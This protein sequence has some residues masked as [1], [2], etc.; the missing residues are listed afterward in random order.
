[1]PNSSEKPVDNPPSTAAAAPGHGL[2]SGG[3]PGRPTVRSL[4]GLLIGLALFGLLLALPNPAGMSIAA[5]RT[6][7]VTVLMAT[8]WI[9]EALPVPAT[10]LLP[11]ALFPLLGAGTLAEATAP[12]ANPILFLF[13]GGFLL[14]LAIERWLL[15]RRIA[16]F[17]LSRVGSRAD[18]IVGGFLL[19]TALLSMWLSNTATAVMMLPIAVSVLGLLDE[20]N[21]AGD[22]DAHPAGASFAPA[23]LLS[24]AYGASIG[25]IATLV[26]T[27]PNAMLA[28]FFSET[29]GVDISFA[30]WMI[31]GLPVSV[32]MLAATWWVLTRGTL[33]VSGEVRG[34]AQLIGRERQKLGSWSRGERMVG[35]MF[36]LTATAWILRP[37]LDLWLP[38]L[39]LSDAGIAMISAIL[40]FALPVD[41]SD[42]RTRF[43]MNWETAQR[44]PWGV[45]LLFGG[46]LSV[47]DRI[48]A[49][50]VAAWIG[51]RFEDLSAWP[52][53]LLLALVVTTIVFLTELTSNAATTATF[54]PVVAAMA[55][56]VGESPL[57]FA[58]PTALAASC[59][60]MM[61]VATPPNA[62]VYGSGRVSIGHM[63]RAG[64]ALNGVA[65][66][67]ILLLGY[68]VLGTAL[69]VRLGD[70]PI[71]AEVAR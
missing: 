36:L 22:A 64:L 68:F 43:L 62:I 31:V 69:G 8:W 49:T 44:V 38:R 30:R 52:L 6:T 47:A 51:L 32:L 1:M 45:L 27:P 12:Y 40:L 18:R 65:I 4:S 10:A 58:V 71:W 56:S 28:G 66:V 55:V 16:L 19:G 20:S 2:H 3:Q 39:S 67:V 34:A 41:T 50:G 42:G 61:P 11:V 14:A 59:A 25:G 63:A 23:L 53:I 17:I 60:F 70:V 21:A 7:A 37:Q 57:L 15:H 24:V 54:L 29:Y 9:L 13:L 35:V 5:W 46:G 33:R 48:N 26:G